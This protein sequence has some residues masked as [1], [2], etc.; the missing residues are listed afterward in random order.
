MDSRLVPEGVGTAG[1]VPLA[2]AADESL[3]G[4]KAISLGTALRAG[5][6][7]PSGVALAWHL[8]ARIAEGD[9]EAVAAVVE[10]SLVP[11]SRL[12]A[13]SSAI[14]EDSGAASFAGQHATKLNVRRHTLVDAVRVV[15]ESA[16]TP[17][18]L[19]YRERKG[20]AA[21]P[22]IGVVVQKLIEPTAAGV[23]FTR[24]PVTG[25]DERLLEASWGLGEAVVN[26]SVVP[27][28]YRCSPAGVVLEFTPGQ[29]DIKIWYGEGQD[30]GTMEVPVDEHLRDL[31]CLTDDHVATLNELADRCG[32]VYGPDLDIEWAVGPDGRVHLL[33]C[34]PITTV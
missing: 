16:Y 5:L 17:S 22:R 34:R 9:S 13:R 2:A 30:D 32:H 19:A 21:P 11:D 1:V 3:F 27:D 14:G 25:A 8:V 24:N 33:Q 28:R 29:K 12:A 31:P 10:S 7:V 26:G 18:A 20:I 15:W 6:P 23:L 4:G